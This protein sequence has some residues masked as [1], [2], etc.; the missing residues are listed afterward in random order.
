MLSPYLIPIYQDAAPAQ[1]LE[2]PEWG[3]LLI[4]RIDRTG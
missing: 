3:L 1:I 2:A 4:A